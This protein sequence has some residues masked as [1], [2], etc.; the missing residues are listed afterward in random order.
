[1]KTYEKNAMMYE[2]IKANVKVDFNLSFYEHPIHEIYQI[3][4]YAELFN[5]KPQNGKSPART[6]YDRLRKYHEQFKA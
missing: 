1:M 3:G 6:L 4:R 2:I 5:I